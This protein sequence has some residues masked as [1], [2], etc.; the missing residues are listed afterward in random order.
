LQPLFHQGLWIFGP[1]YET[2]EF[3]SN[4][5]MTKV[6]QNL[7]KSD[8]KGSRNRPDFAILPD[9]TIGMYY[10]PHYDEEG[11]EF[12]TARLTIVELKRA[13]ISI[14]EEQKTQ[15]WKYIKEL[16]SKGLV[17]ESTKITCFV[18]GSTID[19]QETHPRK[20]K[21]DRVIIKPLDYNNVITRAATRL[22][23]L[24]DRVKSAPFLNQKEIEE[25]IQRGEK[26]V[27][28]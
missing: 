3:T 18:L 10:Y 7:F 25:F 2:I 11:G 6:I 15:C 5:G 14:G 23:R 28:P 26:R 4:E 16:Y 17:D 22:H 27:C 9:S 13:G 1:E 8:E 20:E 24:Y 12:G 21:D 19:S